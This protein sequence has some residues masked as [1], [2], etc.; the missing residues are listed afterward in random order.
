ML[1]IAAALQEELN[2]ALSLRRDSQKIR[3]KGIEFWQAVDR[4]RTIHFIKTGVGPRRSA[5]RLANA[6]EIL[7]VSKILVIGYAGALDPELTLGTLV[8]VEKALSC[9]IDTAN[10][11]VKNMK[12]DGTF[13]LAP[14]VSLVRV[15]ESL[16]IPVR[17]GD[18]VTSSHVWGNPEHKGILLRKFRA[19]IVDMETAALAGVSVNANIP[20]RCIRVVSDEA[21]DS[22]LEPF[23]YD[24]SAGV[25][26]RAGRLIGKGNPLQAFRKWKHN[27]L[28]ARDCLGRFL[29]GYFISGF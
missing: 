8:V 13:L 22:F 16:N 5:E 17:C 4:D 2:V 3:R 20:L 25:P 18:T 7:G 23:S 19:C 27:T 12:L 28:K 14:S 10:P 21:G 1:L 6:I 26:K 29:S 11:A 9:S 15:A 24:P